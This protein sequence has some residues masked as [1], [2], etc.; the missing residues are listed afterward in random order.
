MK[1]NNLRYA[2]DATLIA[3]TKE[4]LVFL[5]DKV[6]EVSEKVGLFRTFEKT[7]VMT[8]GVVD[9]FIVGNESL[10]VVDSFIF[11][12][13]EIYKTGTVIISIIMQRIHHVKSTLIKSVSKIQLT[14]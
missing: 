4:G 10:E 14:T 8:T 6:T 11:L 1:V 13:T 2:D 5:L 7:K 12:G 3:T 9:K